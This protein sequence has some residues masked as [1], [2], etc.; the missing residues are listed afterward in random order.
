MARDEYALSAS[1]MKGLVLGLPIRRGIRM[2]A[3][4]RSNAGASPAW[5]GV[6]TKAHHATVRSR[7]RRAH[8]P[9]PLFTGPGAVLVHAHNRGVDRDDPVQLAV[10]I[11]LGEQGSEDAIS[12]AIDRPV[13]QPCV[14]AFP[15]AVLRGEVHPLR[16]GLELPGDRVDHLSVIAPPPAPPRC[17]VRQQ[18]L[19][20]R[21]LRVSQRHGQ[22]NDPMIG[23]KRPRCH[24]RGCRNVGLADRRGRPLGRGSPGPQGGLCRACERRRRP[25]CTPAPAVAREAAARPHARR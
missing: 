17:P 12:G 18:R 11:G 7:G 1:T 21:P 2:A 9:G 19:Y 8:Q 4:T 5:P 10:R 14:Y 24:P 13:P 23:K 22:T 15:R 20:P 3:I 25:V 6:S 16:A